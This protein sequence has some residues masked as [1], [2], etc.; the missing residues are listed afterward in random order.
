M[1][2]TWTPEG[3]K[4]PSWRY[5]TR[6]KWKKRLFNTIN[7]RVSSFFSQFGK[8][9]KEKERKEW[10][11]QYVDYKRLKDLIKDAYKE[12]EESGATSYSPRTTS[13]T[14]PKAKS[15][16]DTSEELFFRL[17]EAELAKIGTFTEETMSSL[18]SRLYKLQ[19]QLKEPEVHD[20]KDL[21]KVR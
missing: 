2:N 10:T 15:G 20:K 11:G 3:P 16:Q 18:R 4:T 1:F 7:K 5:E 13:L 8:Y 12:Y 17:L 9:L 14:V 6:N 21:L 19:M